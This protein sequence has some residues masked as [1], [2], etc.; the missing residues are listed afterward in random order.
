MP[1][2][3]LL[4]FTPSTTRH[5]VSLLSTYDQWYSVKLP[6]PNN[7]LSQGK[8]ADRLLRVGVGD[9]IL[10]AKIALVLQ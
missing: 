7:D 9:S 4:F 2:S 1:Q 6:P 10:S 8:F 3:R 5:F